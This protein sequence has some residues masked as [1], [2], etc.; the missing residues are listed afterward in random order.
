MRAKHFYSLF[1]FGRAAWLA[2]SILFFLRSNIKDKSQIFQILL[3]PLPP[4]PEASTIIKSMFL[5]TKLFLHLNYIVSSM[6]NIQYYSKILLLYNK[7][8]HYIYPLAICFFLS[9][10]GFH[11]HYFIAFH[12]INTLSCWWTFQLFL[13]FFLLQN[14]L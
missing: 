10:H 2:G 6:Y 1:F 9:T 5:I 8:Y 7:W 3:R 4:S 14:L 12:Y 13:I 11:L